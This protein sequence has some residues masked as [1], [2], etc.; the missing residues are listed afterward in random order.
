MGSLIRITVLLS[1]VSCGQH[2]DHAI[3]CIDSC[4]SVKPEPTPEPVVLVGPRGATGS[5][6]ES[7]VVARYDSYVEI[8][9]PNSDPVVINDGK[10]GIDGEDGIDGQDAVVEI[11][12]PCGPDGNKPQEV[13][14]VLSDGT[15]L[16]WYKNIGLYVLLPNV[17]YQTTDAQAC[18]FQINPYQEL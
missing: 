10:D 6:G 7:C 15:H 8:T 1:L 12:D 4:T 16:A 14:L 13:I 9:C 5:D 2:P 17:T 18:K 3:D 11:I